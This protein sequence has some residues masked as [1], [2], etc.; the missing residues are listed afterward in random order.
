MP[1]TV[2]KPGVSFQR[3]SA[4]KLLISPWRS[5]SQASSPTARTVCWCILSHL[6]ADVP[7]HIR[8]C[9]QVGSEAVDWMVKTGRATD[10]QE[11]TKFGQLLVLGNFIRAAD[12]SAPF[13]DR[14]RFFRSA[15]S[16]FSPSSPLSSPPVGLPQMSPRP[17]V[18]QSQR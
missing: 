13:E 5:K 10:R 14:F 9:P 1:L 6:Y 4:T 16:T 7:L 15:D 18:H 8:S 11:A 17:M 3:S 12:S 2:L